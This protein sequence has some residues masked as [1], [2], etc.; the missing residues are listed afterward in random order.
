MLGA[1]GGLRAIPLP[2]SSICYGDPLILMIT[3]L[4]AHGFFRWLYY[5]L[6]LLAEDASTT[7]QYAANDSLERPLKS[8]V[9]AQDHVDD[10]NVSTVKY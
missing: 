3:D 2:I 6:F 10:Q 5:I 1:L 9:T 8:P 7:S 4:L